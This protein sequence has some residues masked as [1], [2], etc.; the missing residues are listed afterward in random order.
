LDG[1]HEHGVQAREAKLMTLLVRSEEAGSDENGSGGGSS[2]RPWPCAL[3][4]SKG[5]RAR[6]GWRE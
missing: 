5:G 4:N 3:G 1:E 2:A 6:V